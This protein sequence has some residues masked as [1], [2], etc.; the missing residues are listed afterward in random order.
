MGLFGERKAFLH[1]L[2]HA[3]RQ[4]LFSQGTRRS[5]APREQMIGEGERS[6]FVLLILDGWCAIRRSTDRGQ[7]ILALRQTGELVGEMAALDGRPRSAT[8]SALGTVETLTLAGDRFRHF[9]ATRPYANGLV[10]NQLTERLRSS[11]DERRALA[12][13]TVLERLA[14]CLVQLADRAG[15]AEGGTVAIRLP[16]SQHEIAA[17]VGATRE[18]V[19]KAL[20]LLRDEGLVSTGP[21]TIT[22]A[23][24]EPLR[25]LGG[26]P[27]AD[28]TG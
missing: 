21:R 22:V 25:L 28:G 5:Y 17:A 16:L 11:D 8:V 20:R 9:I 24:L 19:A 7:I 12:S 10:M 3:D 4:A 6:T 27:G 1:K 26:R 15:R 2:N 14:A 13:A 18:A 23:D